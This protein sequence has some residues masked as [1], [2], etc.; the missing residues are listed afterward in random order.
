MSVHSKL[1]TMLDDLQRPSTPP[2]YEGYVERKIVQALEE[3]AIDVEDFHYYCVR[4]RKVCGQ[5]KEAA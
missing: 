4:F 3:Q 2:H 1:S 5:R